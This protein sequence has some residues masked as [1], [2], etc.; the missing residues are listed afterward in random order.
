VKRGW[1]FEETPKLLE[2][3]ATKPVDGHFS[4]QID[5]ALPRMI[6]LHEPRQAFLDVRRVVDD[7]Q[8]PLE[9]T[10]RTG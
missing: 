3:I 4:G 7:W 6:R 1:S 2:G 9:L 10:R 5:H 8:M